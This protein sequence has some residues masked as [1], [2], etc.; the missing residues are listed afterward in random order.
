MTIARITILGTTASIPTKHRNHPAIYLHYIGKD[1]HFFL[2]DCGEGTQRQIFKAGLNFM[3]IS[4]IFISH[5]HA[6]HFAGLFGMI[7]TMALEN[8]KKPLYIFGPEADR[9]VP[10]ILNLGY[11]KKPFNIITGSVSYTGS[12][13]ETLLDTNEF[14]IYS[15]PVNHGIPAVAYAFMEKDKIKIDKE[16]LSSLGLPKKSKKYK[17]LKEKGEIEINGKKIM[18]EDVSYVKK[19]IKIVYSGD[20][21]ACRNLIK[22]AKNADCLIIDSTFFEEKP[23]D[24]L[25]GRHHMNVKEAIELGRKAKVKKLVLTHISRR[26]ANEKELIK[27]VKELTKNEKNMEVILARDLI[28]IKLKN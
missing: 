14:T 3:R 9:F 24:W 6:D 15:I 21:K 17:I 7:E 11:G 18:L 4:S 8:R 27:V 13:L 16:K 10:Y 5:W 23:A 2:F 20:T 19:G 12:E 28:E 25:E 1:E 26:Y 22:I